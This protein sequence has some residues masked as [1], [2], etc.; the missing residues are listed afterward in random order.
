MLKLTELFA[1]PNTVIL[2]IGNT[3]R[4]DDAVGPAIAAALQ[5]YPRL[6]FNAGERPE[7]V[8]DDIVAAKPAQLIIIDAAD[9]K[10]VPGEIRIIPGEQIPDTTLSTHQFPLKVIA[11][12]IAQDT[13]AR[14]QFVG[15]QYQQIQPGAA[16]SKSVQ[17]AA[18]KLI[19]AIK[20]A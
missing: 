9:F 4:G 5:G 14:V 6:V 11:K 17:L 2:T 10:G 20:G 18:K 19:T 16:I 8:I 15:I 1:I 3:L 7:G 13:G 12:I